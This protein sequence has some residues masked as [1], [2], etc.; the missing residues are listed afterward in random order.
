MPATS[1]LILRTTKD[2]INNI[3][4]KS[5]GTF[6]NFN[7][8]QKSDRPDFTNKKFGDKSQR[9]GFGDR[10]GMSN[11]SGE[12]RGF[13]QRTQKDSND[14]PKF[15]NKNDRSTD[16][17]DDRQNKDYRKRD[18]DD[19]FNKKQRGSDWFESSDFCRTNKTT[20]EVKWKEEFWTNK[21]PNVHMVEP[22]RDD[23]RTIGI[24]VPSTWKFQNCEPGTFT[25]KCGQTFLYEF[26]QQIHSKTCAQSKKSN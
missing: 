7:K 15:G 4:M 3:T 18:N 19:H 9:G 11:S 5:Q 6:S 12:K 24:C 21:P 14:Q 20:G 2:I 10:M 22:K 23:G 16:R 26:G 17:P 8:N 1:F 25:C 13:G